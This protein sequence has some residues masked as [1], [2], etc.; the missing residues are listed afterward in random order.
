M[1]FRTLSGPNAA[2]IGVYVSDPV[3]ETANQDWKCEYWI[4]GLS[5]GKRRTSHGVDPIQAIYLALTYLATTLYCSKEY[6]DGELTWGDGKNR[7][8]LGLPIAQT[9]RQDI[10]DTMF[11]LETAH[12][13]GRDS[14]PD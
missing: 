10:T 1:L 14:N 8:D 9:I 3:Q 13:C 4:D 11:E 12:S 7:F 5:S 6:K 2:Q